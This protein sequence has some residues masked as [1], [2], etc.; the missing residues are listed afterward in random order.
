MDGA[1]ASHTRLLDGEATVE[2]IGDVSLSASQDGFLFCL[3]LASA[4][5]QLGISQI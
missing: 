4:P 2:V 1:R 5:P 3:H